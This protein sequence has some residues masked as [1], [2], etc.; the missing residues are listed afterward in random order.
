MKHLPV[1]IFVLLLSCNTVKRYQAIKTSGTDNDTL[2]TIDL[3]GTKVDATKDLDT[4]KSLFDLDA[5]GQAELIKEFAKRNADEEKFVA[6]LNNKY[7]KAKE[8]MVTDYTS[9]DAR[10]VFSISK[11]RNYLQ[12]TQ[13]NPS[14]NL[15]DRI[16]Y[17]QFEVA[18][19]DA[20]NLNF[21]KWNKFTTEYANIDVADMTFNQSL[22]VTAGTGISSGFSTENTVDTEKKTKSGGST[23]SISATGTIGKTEVQK[24]RY[25]YVSLNG[26]ISDKKISIEQEGM[27][28][29]DL[30][31]NVIADVSMKFDEFP[32][33]MASVENY[34]TA[35]GAYNMPEKIKVV[36][37]TAMVPALAGLPATIDATLSYQYVYRHVIKGE[38]TFYEWDDEIAYLKG[39]SSKKITLFKKKDYLPAFYNISKEGEDALRSNQRTRLVLQ[40]TNS[41]DETEMI[42][43]SLTAAQEFMNWLTRFDPAPADI[44]KP[45]VLGS[46][47]LLLRKPSGDAALTKQS[48]IA[49][50]STMQVLTYY[51]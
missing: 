15:G 40:D 35:A 28:E 9:K 50:M 7:I 39:E 11:K 23:P 41:R 8:K 18:I 38:K 6:A 49:I 47:K 32:E 17:I 20:I 31:G 46:Y 42:F 19:P 48:F 33:T 22:A 34:K 26:K 27:R 29:I 12:L 25:R 45:I 24:V 16:E 13:D 1:A 43:S 3:F 14:F 10:L 4:S 44:N 5:E 30:S 36:L 2:V 21:I 51:R 37:Y